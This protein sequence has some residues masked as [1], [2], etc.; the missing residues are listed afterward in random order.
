M[1]K[2]ALSLLNEKQLVCPRC[3]S[4]IESSFTI[5]VQCGTIIVK[6]NPIFRDLLLSGCVAA[7]VFALLFLL[8]LLHTRIFTEHWINPFIFFI[9]LWA[10]ALIGLK[11]LELRR[12]ERALDIFRSSAVLEILAGGNGISLSGFEKGII[13]IA[14]ILKRN[15]FINLLNIYIFDRIRKVLNYLKYVP[16]KEEINNTLSYQAQIDQNSIDMEFKM[17]NVFYWAIPIL[18]FIGTVIGIGDAIQGFG[19]F[20]S[21]SS[22]N[23]ADANLRSALG[24]VTTGLSV[25]F[26]ST[27]IALGFA[28]A[29]VPIGMYLESRFSDLLGQVEDYCL[30]FLT[31]NLVFSDS[32]AIEKKVKQ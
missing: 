27:L 5:C 26:D 4:T 28:V 7:L 30:N 2:K 14:A 21:S 31:P 11:Y 25:A 9:S 29:I 8:V 22:G 18:G 16:S 10:M 19:K 15:G 24:N 13:D 6:K 17:I 23:L 12:Q 32:T 1:I 3:R 20:V